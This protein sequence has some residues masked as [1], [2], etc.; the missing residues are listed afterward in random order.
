MAGEETAKGKRAVGTQLHL[1]RCRVPMARIAADTIIP[2]VQTAGYHC[3]MPMASGV[4]SPAKLES[5][6][7]GIR[8]SSFFLSFYVTAKRM[9]KRAQFGN[10]AWCDVQRGTLSWSTQHGVFDFEAVEIL[11]LTTS[12]KTKNSEK[13]TDFAIRSCQ[14][15]IIRCQLR[16]VTISVSAHI[17]FKRIS[18]R[19]WP[20]L[21]LRGF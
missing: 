9:P 10:E 15:S 4:Q 3:L 1:H 20:K 11:R 5:Y 18:P 6:C 12:K 14:L 16:F 13:M 8:H 17:R 19:K 2:A 21:C 7:K